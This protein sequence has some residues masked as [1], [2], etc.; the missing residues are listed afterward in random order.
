MVQGEEKEGPSVVDGKRTLIDDPRPA[1][2]PI[3]WDSKHAAC[4]R[5]HLILLSLPPYTSTTA[6]PLEAPHAQRPGACPSR[7]LNLETLI[8]VILVT[9]RVRFESLP[10]PA[11]PT[12]PD[13]MKQSLPP[14]S[15][16]PLSSSLPVTTPPYTSPE[17]IVQAA[18]QQRP[19]MY[20]RPMHSSPNLMPP[21]HNMSPRHPF[22]SSS[23]SMSMPPSSSPMYS[24]SVYSQSLSPP[25]HFAYYPQSFPSNPYVQYQAPTPL[26]P[27]WQNMDEEN[28]SG[29]DIDT[30]M[31]FDADAT[32]TE[33]KSVSA[34]PSKKAA[35]PAH[36]P[37]PPNAW[38]LYRSD[39]LRA[40]GAGE[41]LPGLEA[42]MAETGVSAS[43]TEASEESSLEDKGKGKEKE[44]ISESG[45]MLPPPVPKK[46][47]AK[48]GAKEPTEGLLSLGRGKTGRGLPQADIS[49]MISM[50]W[51]R[52]SPEVRGEYE[53]LS[54]M[55]KLEVSVIC[56]AIR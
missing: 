13:A 51:K 40:I 43:S 47:K 30:D 36:T 44:V 18:Q 35:R 6:V 42:I 39:K 15:Q 8:T 41:Q 19:Q 53:R 11:V 54:E 24:P 32:D 23:P 48:K 46:K 4:W 16:A 28:A 38:I 34:S 2:L 12:M 29:L 22:P 9:R 55:K 7:V 56:E 45:S 17:E 26:S 14:T 27:P 21:P 31:F 52:E 33:V 20:S 50:L 10:P 1:A 49:K 25:Q 37:R 5:A 3:L